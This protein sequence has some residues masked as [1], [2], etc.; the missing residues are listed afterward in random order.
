MANSFSDAEQK[1]YR[2]LASS[3]SNW[4]V[5]LDI[6]LNICQV[7]S[8]HLASGNTRMSMS[9]PIWEVPFSVAPT[10]ELKPEF[11]GYA[12]LYREALGS[13]SPVYAFL[14]LFKIVEGIQSRR[15]R[16]AV[17]A[18]RSGIA[19]IRPRRRVPEKPEERIPW[20]NAI[21]PIRQAWDPMA[22]DSIFRPEAL[23]KKFGDVI[24][25]I[26]A[27][28][29]VNIAHALSLQS[30]EL[31]LSV[32]ELLH[33]QQVNNWLP[34][35]KCIVRRMLK[36]EFPTEFLPYLKEDGTIVP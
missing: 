35:T 34:L 7:D 17:E 2:A 26:L 6:P 16:L 8:T 32:D 29:R 33:T 36:D 27:P 28:L 10:V 19:F 21:F 4:S 11:R 30:G 12:S 13:N 3:L 9:T 15:Q 25:K 24:D 14:C 5:H 31:T 22:L 23:G 1:A 18:K 20:L